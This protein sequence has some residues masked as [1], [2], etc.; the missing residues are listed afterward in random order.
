MHVHVCMHVCM[1]V[2]D[3]HVCYS[4]IP[5]KKMTPS[6]S[7][8][9][10]GPNWNESTSEIGTFPYTGHFVVFGM[11]PWVPM[12]KGHQRRPD[13]LDLSSLRSLT[14]YIYLALQC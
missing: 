9:W 10:L 14:H 4:G 2:Y 11:E 13:T 6:I 8:Q 5:L 12:H 1:Q 7:G 3:V